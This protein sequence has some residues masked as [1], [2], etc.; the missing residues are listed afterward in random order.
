MPDPS[1]SFSSLALLYWHSRNISGP[2]LSRIG[3]R[4]GGLGL[5]AQCDLST[6]FCRQSSE[7]RKAVQ[8]ASRSSQGND[9]IFWAPEDWGESTTVKGERE[10]RCG[11]PMYRG[12]YQYQYNDM[13]EK[14]KNPCTISSVRG[15]AR[16]C[17]TRPLPC[18]C[19]FGCARRCPPNYLYSLL[20]RRLC[21]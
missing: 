8:V 6:L 1:Y 4:R 20:W 2:P 11:R 7:F 12:E 14:K 15:C 3:L 5:S 13:I 16:R 9:S 10:G 18:T 19:F 17:L 21:S